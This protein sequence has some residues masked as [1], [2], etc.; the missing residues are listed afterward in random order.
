MPCVSYVSHPVYKSNPARESG[1]QDC[2]K[3]EVR[4]K[5]QDRREGAEKDK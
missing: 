4:A 1:R 3:A 2:L 5:K